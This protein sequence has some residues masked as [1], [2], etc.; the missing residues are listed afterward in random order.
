VVKGGGNTGADAPRADWGRRA[1]PYGET[2]RCQDTLSARCPTDKGRS[3]GIG[4]DEPNETH[5]RRLARTA[6]AW[7]GKRRATAACGR[8]EAARSGHAARVNVLL[9]PSGGAD[10]AVCV[11]IH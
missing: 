5:A 6:V 11:G 3:L 2:W 8:Q 10:F 9:V 4:R 1:T 7:R